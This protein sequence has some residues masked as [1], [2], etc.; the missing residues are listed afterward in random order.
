MPDEGT[1]ET[2]ETEQAPPPSKGAAEGSKSDDKKADP[3]KV[4]GAKDAEYWR[5]KAEKSEQRATALERASMTELDR[6]KAERDEWK[7]IAEGNQAK[8]KE[9]ELRSAFLSEA[10]DAG[11]HDTD[12]AWVLANKANMAL[13]E[14]GKAIGAAAAILALKKS[15]PYLFDSDGKLGSGG[16]KGK[17]DSTQSLKDKMNEKIR[18][19]AFGG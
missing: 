5:K 1:Q 4:E 6:A 7:S 15:K 9:N 18:R 17:A 12:A 8:I 3:A 16:G 13:S 2:K 11:I 19:Q 14:D 10:A